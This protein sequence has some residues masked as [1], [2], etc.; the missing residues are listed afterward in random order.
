MGP[1][2]FSGGNVCRE[3]RR[4][5]ADFRAAKSRSRILSIFQPTPAQPPIMRRDDLVGAIMRGHR[6]NGI[7]SSMAPI[8]LATTRTGRPNCADSSPTEEPPTL[9]TW[10]RSCARMKN[11][12]V[13]DGEHW[14]N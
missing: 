13:R 1:G 3:C 10:P 14:P 5:I 8:P 4:Y 9:E 6:R 11:F 12:D 7:H 2:T